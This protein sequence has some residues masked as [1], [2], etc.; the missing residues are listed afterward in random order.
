M[1]HNAQIP[2]N[3][4]RVSIDISIEDDALPP[5]PIDEDTI[6]I[7]GA[8]CTYVA[9]PIHLIDVE[10]ASKKAKV[11]KS[12]PKPQ[13]KSN[14]ES[15]EEVVPKKTNFYAK[16]VKYL[17]KLPANFTIKIS[18]PLPIFGFFSR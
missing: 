9:W 8:I 2:F 5:I 14:V 12:K 18:F 6:T 10:H 4:V 16:L 7:G 13:S 15:S 17:Q 11:V 3:H 1:L